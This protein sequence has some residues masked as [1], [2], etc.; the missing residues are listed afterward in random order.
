MNY[1]LDFDYT[2]FNTYEFRKGLYKILEEN[3]LDKNY[4][5]ITPEMKQN[6]PKLLNVKEV[7]KS[8]S[9]SKNIPLEKFLAPLKELY[10][11]AEKF[12]YSDTIEFIKY[13]KENENKVYILTWGDKEFQEE[14]LKASKLY[15]YF[16]GII[17]AEKLKY[18][19]EIDYENSIFVDDSIRDLKGLYNKNAKQIYRIKR[20]NGKNSNKELNI[21]EIK[22]FKS[23]KELQDYLKEQDSTI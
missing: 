18:E 11:M 4:L 6:N 12:V 10:D 14:K 17:Y 3:G 8:L 22:E 2:L 15:N 20:I 19:L 1:Y 21:K 9:K 23:L 16:D 7:F 5:K 13:L